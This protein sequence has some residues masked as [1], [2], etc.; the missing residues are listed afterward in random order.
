MNGYIE[1]HNRNMYLA[2]VQTG[3]SKD[4]LKSMKNYGT[5]LNQQ[6][7]AQTI[8]IKKIYKNQIQFR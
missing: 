6:L 8:M 3:K 7:I 5:K 4:T 2:L 1:E